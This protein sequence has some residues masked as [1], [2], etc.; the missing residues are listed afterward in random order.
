[1]KINYPPLLPFEIRKKLENLLSWATYWENCWN[2]PR[3]D[4]VQD[5]IQELLKK[6][7]IIIY[8]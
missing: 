2:K 6:H 3:W 5:E 4:K 7:K 8:N 1:M